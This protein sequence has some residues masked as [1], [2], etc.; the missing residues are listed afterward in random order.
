VVDAAAEPDTSSA[1][2]SSHLPP[3]APLEPG[4]P[5]KGGIRGWY[6]G[7]WLVVAAFIAQFVSVGAQNYVIGS[8]LT[9]MTEELDWSRTEFTFARTI[10]QF[11]MAFTGVFIG[12][13]V[14]QHGGKWLMRGGIVVMTAA[15]FA[16]GSVQELWQWLLLNG[17]ILTIGAAMIG[18]LVVNVTIS[19]WF[20]E[21]RGRM[22]G[23]ASMG[24]S[25]AGIAITPFSA[26]LVEAFGWRDSWRILA[27]C[28]AI[29]IVPLSF[30]MR[31]APEDHGLHPD[32]KSAEQIAQ[33]GGRAAAF[34]FASSLTRAEAVRLPAF[35]IVAISFGLGTIS[36]G[37][38]LIHTIP[39]ME[40]AGFSKNT[41]AAMI[42]VTSIPALLLKPAWGYFMDKADIQKISL[43]G[44]VLN[45]V[46]LLLIVISVRADTFP[47]IVFSF[48]LLGCGWSGFIPLQEVVWASFFGRRYL[49]AVRS[50]GLPV[51]LSI[52]ASAPLLI[53]VYFD[54]IGDYNG[55]FLGIAALSLIGGALLTFAH[56]PT[57]VERDL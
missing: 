56:P 1:A 27:V 53:A 18:N 47:L 16:L 38:L 49:G 43:I 33:G 52:S 48:A 23:F 11:I 44:F 20:V 51:A 45:A 19:K 32:G 50:A 26:Y 6:Y 13:L 42:T 30:A 22:V 57:R 40:D 25:F 5:Q 46:A 21:R 54:H 8:F 41:A 24:V 28:A 9:P 4:T 3:S 12:G 31:R 7:Y 10:G 29:V 55:A 34:D 36:I 15:M 14:D 35:Y 2:D 39:F 17:L 37:A